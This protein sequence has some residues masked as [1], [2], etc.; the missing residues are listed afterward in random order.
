M[1]A[2]KGISGLKYKK[3][4]HM[5]LK[6]PCYSLSFEPVRFEPCAA[7][8]VS[9]VSNCFYIGI[10]SCLPSAI[11]ANILVFDAILFACLSQQ[12]EIFAHSK[13][14]YLLNTFL[15]SKNVGNW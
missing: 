10:S 2:R 14:I 5:Y 3:D 7:L 4:Q 8:R 6:G 11:F 13:F 9:Q 1:L 15:M 12:A